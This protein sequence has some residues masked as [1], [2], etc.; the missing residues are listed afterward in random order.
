MQHVR[1]TFS[2]G[3]RE[4]DVHPMYGLLTNGACVDRASALQWNFTGS[5]FGILHY[6]EGDREAFVEQVEAIP[7]VDGYDVLSAGSDVFYAYIRDD[8]TPETQAIFS[9]FMQQPMVVVPPIE[10]R[11]DGASCS[12]FGRAADV[13][14][15]IDHVPA[16]M[17][18]EVAEV[19]G[20]AALP[21][22]VEPLLTDRQREAIETALARGY[23]EIPRTASHEDVADE[24]GCAPSTAAEHLRKAESTLIQ[25]VIDG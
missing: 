11:D 7:E 8:A 16:P 12:V 19:S 9:A 25:A 21:G 14:V 22:V 4:A 18:V 1:L 3:G 15:V 23:Y 13:Q 2:A 17:S 20:M 24:M 6:V 10:Y 5:Q